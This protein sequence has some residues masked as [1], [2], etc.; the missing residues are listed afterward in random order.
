MLSARELNSQALSNRTWINE[1]LTF[2]HGYGLTLGPVNQ[3]TQR[4][5]AGAL[6]E[7][8][9]AGLDRRP[10]GDRAAALLR[11][12]VERLRLRRHARARV[13]LPARRRQ[14]HVPLQRQRRRAGRL[15]LAQAAV[16]PA[17]PLAAGPLQQRHR[18]RRAAC[19]STGAST[20]ASEQ[21]APFLRYEGDP[22][23][24]VAGGRLVLDGGRLHDVATAIPYSTPAAERAQL[25]PQRRQGRGRRLPRH[26]DVLSRRPDRSDCARHRPRVFPGLLQPLDEMP[27]DAA[28]A[29]PLPASALRDADGDVR[30]LP[31]DESRWSSTTRKTS[32]SCRSI[33]G[34]E[35][36]RADAAV[37]HDHEAARRDDG[38]SSSRWCR[39]RRAARTTSRPGWSARSDGD[40]LRPAD[41]LPVPEAEGRLRPAP[42]RRA[43]QPGPG[44][45]AADHAVEP[46]GLAR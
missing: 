11:R 8:P 19:C 1:H 9:A 4:R 17:L 42:G 38:R 45:L 15:V 41:R 34:S 25:H 7:G 27:A 20:S 36:A 39:S 13:R 33:D 5:A 30:D 14:R 12:A 37:L 43:D 28:R 10:R 6:R 26:D 2:T 29:H 18:R 40:A 46:A 21:I 44:D 22:Y 23:L 3:V 31:H 16:R 35:A 24:V 32:G